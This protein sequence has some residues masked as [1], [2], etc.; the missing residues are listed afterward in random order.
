MRG[1]IFG[2]NKFI[3]ERL[4]YDKEKLKDFYNQR[5]FIDFNV[6][7]ARGDL[8]P[9]FS[10]F[11]LNF[12]INE[13]DKYT[14][15]K[16]DITSKLFDEKSQYLLKQLYMEKGDVFDS[17]ALEESSKFL[18]DHLEKDGFNFVKVLP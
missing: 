2:S 1:K 17:R 7:V 13:G 3:P 11:N 5:G 9:N 18:I 6:I 12:I 10:G 15:N 8:L 14:I 16:I 4:E